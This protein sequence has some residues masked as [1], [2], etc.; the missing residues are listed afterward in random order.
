MNDTMRT[1]M[2]EATRLTRQGHL[3]EAT[4]LIQQTLGAVATPGGGVPPHRARATTE[5]VTINA[6]L[7]A[8]AETKRT[9][10]APDTVPPRGHARTSTASPPPGGLGSRSTHVRLPGN[11]VLPGS[12]ILPALGDMRPRSIIPPAAAP[13]SVEQTQ[14][15]FLQA[16]FAGPAGGRGY[17]LYIP[18]GYAGQAVPLLVMLHGCT[19]TPEDF[20]AGT[21]INNLADQ[22]TFLVAYPAQVTSANPSRC[23]NWFEDAHQSRAAGEPAILAG[24]T[25]QVMA[26]YQVDPRRVYVAGLSAG[27]AMAAVLAV[28][29]PDLFAAVGVHSGLAYGAAS[30]LIT[31]M[32]AMQRG[33]AGARLGSSS[34][35]AASGVPRRGVPLILFHGESDTT[36]HPRNADQLLAQWIAAQ[37]DMLAPEKTQQV[38]EGRHTTRTVYRD[39]S[40]QVVVEQWKVQGLGHAWFGGSP[41]GSF[42]D[43][44]GPDASAEMVRFFLEHPRR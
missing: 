33:G 29:H 17:R 34:K 26:D 28:T 37:G 27:G 19:Q 5:P 14:G 35:S 32:A 12:G 25:Q 1:R 43:A 41:S 30:D 11:I 22:H 21:R 9:P 16:S 39:S 3:A 20:A 4:A 13:R 44:Q 15:R 18:P 2:A 23:W 42:T 38:T 40:G 24:L 6:R 31:A 10:D 8:G 7:G 36:V